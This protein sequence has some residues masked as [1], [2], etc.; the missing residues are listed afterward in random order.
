[1]GTATKSETARVSID[2]LRVG[3]KLMSPIYDDQTSL[4]LIA[5]GMVLT[6][7]MLTKLT[8]RGIT[9]VR[10]SVA[11]LA[12]VTRGD[13]DTAPAPKLKKPII[14]PSK[15]LPSPKAEKY[16]S[17]WS[18][19]E[20]A[21]INN[22]QQP[23]NVTGIRFQI[24]E[25]SK[26]F[27]TSIVAVQDAFTSLATGG[28]INGA[29]LR[30]S[31]E[32]ALKELRQDID[33]YLMLGLKCD[34]HS[35]P[36]SHSLQTSRLAMA[37]GAALGLSQEGL[38][39]LGLGCLV[40]DVGMLKVDPTL[41]NTD[42]PLDHIEKLDISKHPIIAFEMLKNIPEVPPGARMVAYQMHERM[43]GSGYPRRRAGVQIHALSRIA[44]VADC[45]VAMISP[46]PHRPPVPPYYAIVEL[47]ESAKAHQFDPNAVKALIT[48]VG[49]FPL[50][51]FVELSDGRIGE[52]MSNNHEMFSRPIIE[53][54]HRE[55]IEV[56]ETIDLS[57]T[58]DVTIIRPMLAA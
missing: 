9:H 26:K 50:G 53:A 23:R 25:L 11:D 14:E 37:M 7:Q 47:L 48:V 10:V 36:Y 33:L 6:K 54:W 2:G 57:E 58:E 56:R 32:D 8:N 4:L 12:R 24:P 29:F 34:E 22:V 38:M 28:S 19:G 13:G 15:I 39:E 52:V 3:A 1:M 5:G 35:Y 44:M 40:H 55:S 27:S 45:F 16:K 31:T 41:L 43:D 46:R 42:K 20:N 18:A 49:L 51:S 30:K 17:P 21:F